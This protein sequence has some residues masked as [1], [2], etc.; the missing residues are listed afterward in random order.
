MGTS[1]SHLERE[2]VPCN[3]CGSED[4]AL[5]AHVR[6]VRV[7]RC[8]ECGLVFTNPRLSVTA[9]HHSYE[10]DYGEVHEDP[11]LLA[12]RRRMYEIE[13][14]ELKRWTAGE[15][16]GP[17]APAVQ[18]DDGPLR[19]LDVGCG[20]GEFISLLQNDF[21]VYGV[22]VSR[23]YLQIAQERYGLPHLVHG[24]LTTARFETGFFD[25]VQMRGVLQHLPDPLKQLREAQRVTKPGGWLIISATPNI[26]SP[27]ARV[28]GPNFRLMAPDQM[29]YDF[30]P[31]TLRQM[32]QRA[33]YEVQSFTF[34]YVR[35]PYF[36]WTQA[37][38]FAWLA[39]KLAGRKI[40]SRDTSDIR[41]PAFFGSMMT[42]LARKPAV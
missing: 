9:L 31:R 6:G 41:S 33:G 19:F 26:T 40:A 14:E 16:G 4:H 34:P 30:S 17:R 12:Q 11:V 32:L 39:M 18:G 15:V 13:R 8:R 28:F 10:E 42:C 3:L 35:T 20:T 2:T 38:E 1:P 22:E 25:V 36:R 37:L 27:A 7:V 5:W 23:R 24:E 29:V 21:E